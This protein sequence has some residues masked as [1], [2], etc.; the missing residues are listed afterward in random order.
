MHCAR[1]HNADQYVDDATAV[2][3]AVP[4]LF[5][6]IDFGPGQ[7]CQH[8]SALK[9]KSSDWLCREHEVTINA[10]LAPQVLLLSIPVVGP[11]IFIPMQAATAW[12]VDLLVKQSH[13][14][15][16]T[17]SVHPSVQYNGGQTA[18]NQ[19]APTM[20]ASAPVYNQQGHQPASD[21]QA[22]YQ[23]PGYPSANGYQH[24][25]VNSM[26]GYQQSASPSQFR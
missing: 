20:P 21:Q 13:A 15:S 4:I 16:Q 2:I 9:C 6:C 17:Q 25:A 3:Q 5:I 1:G 24:P 14:P 22:P 10:F 7:F 8:Y 26:S 23:P 12:L 18:A 19:S 11:I